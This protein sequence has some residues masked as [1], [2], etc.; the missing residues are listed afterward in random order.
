LPLSGKEI[1]RLLKQNGWTLIR[2][3]GSH[4]VLGKGN[5]TVT[6]PIHGNRSLGVG[7]EQKILKQADLKK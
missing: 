5:K 4:H 1:L 6:V 7:L 3:N 2:I